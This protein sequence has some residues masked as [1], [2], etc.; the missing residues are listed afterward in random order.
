MPDNMM[1]TE[2]LVHR[3][4][5]PAAVVSPQFLDSRTSCSSPVGVLDK[6]QNHVGFVLGRHGGDMARAP[7][8]DDGDVIRLVEA[9]HAPGRASGLGKRRRRTSGWSLRIF[10]DSWD[11]L[12]AHNRKVGETTVVPNRGLESVAVGVWH[13]HSAFPLAAVQLDRPIAAR[14][15]DR[16]TPPV[17][18]SRALAVMSNFS[19][20]MR[21]F[22]LSGSS[23]V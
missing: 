23:T 5:E 18:G 1:C 7:V 19:T 4:D 21:V 8:D 17:S 22:P 3:V 15:P 20:A 11:A 16:C 10:A 9:A 12:L 13:Q 14:S 6:V 2:I